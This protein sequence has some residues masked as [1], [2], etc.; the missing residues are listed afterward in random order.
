MQKK[1]KTISY[2]LLEIIK[3]TD[4]KSKNMQLRKNLR[5]NYDF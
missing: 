1:K 2:K 3:I 4:K 5:S